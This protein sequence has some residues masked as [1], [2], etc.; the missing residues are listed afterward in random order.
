MKTEIPFSRTNLVAT[1]SATIKLPSAHGDANYT[2]SV[3]AVN[4]NVKSEHL[5]GNATESVFLFKGIG[6]SRTWQ[7]K[8]RLLSLLSRG[9]GCG[10]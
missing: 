10:R 4:V 5:P 1:K 3:R 7:K 6:K 8:L 2:V 9:I